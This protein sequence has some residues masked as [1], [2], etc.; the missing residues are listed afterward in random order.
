MQNKIQLPGH[1]KEIIG[2]LES[3]SFS[4]Y[5]VG[6]A[7]RDS[8]LDR[9]VHDWDICTNALPEDV[10]KIFSKYTVVPTG[11]KHGTVSIIIDG[12]TY[13]VST[14]RSDGNYSDNR[15]PDNVT[16][17]RDIRN[18]LCRRDFT[19]NAMAYNEKEGL[20]DPYG[21]QQ[22]LK[23]KIINCVGDPNLRIQEDA[24]RMLR[25][26]RFASQLG[27][28]IGGVWYAIMENKNL[29]S[30][31]S[32]ERIRDELNKILLSDNP[33]M[34]AALRLTGL[35]DIIIPELQKCFGIDQKN[36]N[37]IYDVGYH[38]I[39]TIK[40]TP[41]N[42]ILRLS[43]MLHDIGKPRTMTVDANGVGHFYRHEDVSCDMAGEI[44][45]RLKYDNYTIDEV[46]LLVKTHMNCIPATKRT[47][48]RLL[49]Q[50]GE[51]RIMAWFALKDADAKAR[52]Q[53]SYL[54]IKNKIN[55][56]IDLYNQVISDDECFS[57]KDLAINGDDLK[58][59]GY[60]EGKKIGQVLHSCLAM[61]IED[62]EKNDKK[63]L[64]EYANK[65]I[66][67]NLLE[68]G[69]IKN[70]IFYLEEK[71]KMSS[72]EFL[73]KV[74]DKDIPDNFETMTWKTMIL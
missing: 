50:I 22:D 30:N 49:N 19:I 61:V 55:K 60:K 21:G 53:S 32:A 6:G 70:I 2:L 71:Y 26:I 10:I 69:N 4:A 73:K 33:E 24:L 16:F 41:D 38:I 54:S 42:L 44:L 25:A 35:L 23:N 28:K 36:K 47:M 34:I 39:Y 46:C 14:F 29:I 18:D 66:F 62:A 72:D 20:I 12:N 3:N 63:Y 5:V 37:H 45:Q 8:L 65:T 17:I 56:S 1:V 59:I 11:L 43:A 52:K 31:V 7:I 40:N 51:E 74:S 9:P 58:D 13:E 68:K 27:F 64:L 57:L 15:H 67:D 48:R